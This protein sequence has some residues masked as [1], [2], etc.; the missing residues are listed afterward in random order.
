[1]HEFR[2]LQSQTYLVETRNTYL[3]KLHFMKQL[4]EDIKSQVPYNS[5]LLK[6]LCVGTKKCYKLFS[7]CYASL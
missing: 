1:M 6:N 4:N 7:S 3:C 5:L 2:E